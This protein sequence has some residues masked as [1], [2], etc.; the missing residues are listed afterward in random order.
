[1]ARQCLFTSYFVDRFYNELFA[2]INDYAEI[3]SDN[4]N[5]RLYQVNKIAWN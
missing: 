3:N 1:M 5:L 4:L 2:T